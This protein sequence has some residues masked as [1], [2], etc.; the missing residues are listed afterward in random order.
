MTAGGKLIALGWCRP[1][2]PTSSSSWRADRRGSDRQADRRGRARSGADAAQADDPR[3]SSGNMFW[4]TL[5]EGGSYDPAR[6]RRS[7]RSRATSPRLAREIQAL[8]AR[9]LRPDKDWSM[10]VVPEEGRQVNSSP[11]PVALRRVKGRADHPSAD[12]I[13]PESSVAARRTPA[14]STCRRIF[15]LGVSCSFSIVNGPSATDE[16]A[17]ALDHRQSLFTRSTAWPSAAL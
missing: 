14:L 7:T 13:Q 10:V 6:S 12:F 2:R 4:M 3:R 15:R 1:T 5:V 11:A 17:H 16:L 8:A 9:Y